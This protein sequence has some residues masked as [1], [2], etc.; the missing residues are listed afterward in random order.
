MS[1]NTVLSLPLDRIASL[2]EEFGVR[3]LAVFGSTVRGEN[4]A[5]SDLDL[6]VDFEPAARIG[7]LTLASLTEELERLLHRRVDLVTKNGLKP[8]MRP[9]ILR[10]AQVVY[11]K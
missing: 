3:E 5:D 8:W 7:L 6:L 10:E 9:Q 1:S 2:C 4:R 11:S